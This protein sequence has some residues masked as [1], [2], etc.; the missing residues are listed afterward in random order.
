MP[1]RWVF[2]VKAWLKT[3][4]NDVLNRYGAEIVSTRTLYEWQHGQIDKSTWNHSPLPA[5][6]AQYLSPNNP[7]LIDLQQRYKA[8]D[9]AVTNPFVWVDGYVSPEDMTYFRGD[10]A[11]V[12]QVRGKN[13]NILAYALSLYYLKS[14]DHLGLFEKLVEDNSFGNFTFPINGRQV[15]RDLID[16]IAEISFLDR[17]LGITSRQGFRVLDIGAGYGRLAHRML[18]AVPGIDS[19]LCTDA[20]AFSTFVSEYYL[21]FR[22]VEKA[23]VIPLDEIDKTLHDHP[24]DLAVNIHSFS[25]CRDE[26]I[27]WWVRLLSKHRVKYL[28]IVPNIPDERMLTNDWRDFLPLVERHG[29][30]TIVKEPKFLDPV[31]Q[32]YGV[33]PSW[34]HLL[35][36]SSR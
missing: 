13:A 14:I 36:L 1:D 11:W 28:M 4:I 34:Y 23:A 35:E 7:K 16:S 19:Y 21:R 12:W 31:V 20:V 27:E 5:D 15:S 32:E 2:G 25:E 33:H 18:T 17:H 8:F 26:A 9:S 29:Y 3:R 30:R 10:N 22:N 24:V 6:A